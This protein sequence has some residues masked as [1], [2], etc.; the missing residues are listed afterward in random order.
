MR[1][2]KASNVPRV[3]LAVVG[4]SG[5]PFPQRPEPMFSDRPIP[6]PS[7]SPNRFQQQ[8]PP[9]P[10]Q[11]QKIKPLR[12]GSRSHSRIRILK[13]FQQYWR[14]RCV[15]DRKK[16]KICYPIKEKKYSKTV[17]FSITG[18]RLI[19]SRRGFLSAKGAENTP[20]WHRAH[21]Y[22]CFRHI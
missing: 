10:Q 18:K 12:P 4:T 14:S 19:G 5:P 3:V 22:H 17:L 6:S 13:Y 15:T 7:T 2:R 9:K 8:I 16:S 1:R 20:G 11:D 21:S